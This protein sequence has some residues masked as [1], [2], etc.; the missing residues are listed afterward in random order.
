[1]LI[2]T[3]EVWKSQRVGDKILSQAK[4][5]YYIDFNEEFSA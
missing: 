5:E 2:T 1:M 4:Q 3:T